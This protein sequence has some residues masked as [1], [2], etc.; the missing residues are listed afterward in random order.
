MEKDFFSGTGECLRSKS[1]STRSF[2]GDRYTKLKSMAP[3]LVPLMAIAFSGLIFALDQ[4]LG[5]VLGVT[6]GVGLMGGMA[7]MSPS[8]MTRCD[9]NS[10]TRIIN[11]LCPFIDCKGC[12]CVE[13]V[14][15]CLECFRNCLSNC[16]CCCC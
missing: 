3:V 14:T 9:P 13:C 15:G 10:C 5:I 16:C 4:P 11:R 2:S 12:F 7:Q 1:F 8:D 6:S